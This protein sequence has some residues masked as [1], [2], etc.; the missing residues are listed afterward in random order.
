MT[1]PA[2]PVLSTGTFPIEL[3][4]PVRYLAR[5]PILDLH[6]R[7]H[8]Y[9]LLY[10]EGQEKSFQGEANHATRTTIDDTVVFGVQS[11][12]GGFPA[13]VNCTAGALLENLVEALPPDM[14]V[15]EILETV[16]PTPE[17][18]AVCRRLKGQGY[19]IALDD[20]EW[21]PELVPLTQL[22]DYI[23][24]DFRN[25][26]ASDRKRILGQ[27]QG[28][29]GA[30][31][32]EKV[33]TRAEYDQARA[34]G[35]TLFQGYY[36]CQPKLMAK[37]KVPANHLVHMQ[38]L[39]MLDKDPL[40]LTV[41]SELVKR[42]PSLTYRLIR[43]VNSA[44]MGLRQEV[45]SITTALMVIGDDLFRR[46]ALLAI[47][48][49]ANGGQPAEIVRMAFVRARFCELGSTASRVDPMEEYLLGLFSMLPAMLQ[50]PM[51]EA[52]ADLPLRTSLRR[53][54][55]GETSA[56]RD[57]LT[58]LEFHERGDWEVCDRLAR[59]RE[60]DGPK[61][62]SD[63]TEAVVWADDLISSVS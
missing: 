37:R 59:E 61:L 46:I 54:L 39:E 40:D 25:S 34:E 3:S 44:G 38:L 35:F 14:A 62:L 20:F 48:S 52:I 26:D 9:E 28:F 31:L 12:T 51:G 36:F 45:N 43:L 13:F 30:L 29:K 16:E 63:F 22:A 33:E 49:E 57:R 4:V 2:T 58:W 15:L 8:G 23:K 42:D 17:L 41:V 53:A 56:A 50:V 6:G 1:L 18:L 27:L 32:A 11:L 5:Q 60:L 7:V 19:R 10:R 47:A 21:R 24:I 55:L